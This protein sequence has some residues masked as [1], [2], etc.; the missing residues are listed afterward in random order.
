MFQG[1]HLPS[2]PKEPPEVHIRNGLQVPYTT[3]EIK[4]RTEAYEKKKAIWDK[5]MKVSPYV[6]YVF[7]Y[8]PS[9]NSI[10]HHTYI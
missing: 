5:T 7:T 10:M 3:A 6:P 2:M 8:I 4:V 1:E 9:I